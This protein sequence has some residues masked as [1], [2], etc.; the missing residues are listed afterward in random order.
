MRTILPLT[1]PPHNLKYV[2]RHSIL[3]FLCKRERESQS[4]LIHESRLLKEILRNEQT[5]DFDY[6][7]YGLRCSK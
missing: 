2:Y 5:I 3:A 6:L 1:F 7:G 4:I